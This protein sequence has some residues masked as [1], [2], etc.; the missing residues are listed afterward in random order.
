MMLQ[1]CPPLRPLPLQPGAIREKTRKEAFK[2]KM[3]ASVSNNRIAVARWKTHR[4]APA[5]APLRCARPDEALQKNEK[6]DTEAIRTLDKMKAISTILLRH[7]APKVLNL[8]QKRD[9]AVA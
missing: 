6:H 1:L 9:R 5:L 8:Q 2:M 3:Q 7:G 4:F